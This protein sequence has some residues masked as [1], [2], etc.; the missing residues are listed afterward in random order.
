MS[1][2]SV[3]GRRR[4]ATHRMVP[5]A[6][7]RLTSARAAIAAACLD[8]LPDATLGDVQLREDQR[9]TLARAMRALDQHGGCLVGEDVGRGKTF[10]ALA[11]ARRW[12]RPLVIVPAVLR[13]TWRRASERAHVECVIES[14]ECLSRGRA[15]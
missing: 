11:L 14:H 9:L 8:A 4:C 10:I 7:A 2:I 12:N 3:A 1:C 13:G 15:P 6:G 5:R